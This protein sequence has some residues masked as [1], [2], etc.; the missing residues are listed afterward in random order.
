MKNKK[1]VLVGF[2]AAALIACFSA[3]LL[4]S[5]SGNN[6][7]GT[8][9]VAPG[10]VG[11][12]ITDD[13]SLFTRVTATINSV[14]VLNTGS[15]DSCDMLTTPLAVNIAGL[16]NVMHLASIVRCPAAS[17][18][19]IRIEFEK[20]VV[21]ATAATGTVPGTTSLCSFVS[22][23]DAGNAPNTLSCSGT[24]CSLDITGAVNVLANQ[25]SKLALDFNLKE[26]DVV[27][28]GTPTTCTVT[29]KVSPLHAGEVEALGEPESITGLVSGL[30]TTGKNLHAHERVF[31]VQRTLLRNHGDAAAGP[32]QPAPGRRD[33]RFARQ[34]QDRGH[35]PVHNDHHGHCRIREARGNGLQ[36]GHD[37]PYLYHYR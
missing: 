18:N 6:G 22:Y 28:F 31:H 11:L 35:G 9:G 36:P 1:K 27:G 4:Y 2:I 23:K 24:N 8:G 29:M 13:M 3:F 12:Y 32:R 10:V 34:G 5:C 21:L 19:R 37:G 33:R 30:S 26:F 16:A 17:Y 20:N 14:Q 7:S 15:G 25:Q